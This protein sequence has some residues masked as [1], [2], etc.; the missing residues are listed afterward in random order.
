VF[1]GA[2]ARQDADKGDN[3]KRLLLTSMVALVS[4]ATEPM[5][6]SAA[7]AVPLERIFNPALTKQRPGTGSLIVKR[8]PG[9]KGSICAF[10]LHE[11]GKLF[12]EILP[13]EKVQIYLA[14]GD[15][16]IGLKT[17]M[18]CDNNIEASVTLTEGQ[19]RTYRAGMGGNNELLLHPTAF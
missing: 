10:R 16:I 17:D 5:P 13:G 4:C 9:F 1:K 2:T 3:M 7:V 11:G 15:H 19:T 8:D 14:P 6:T 18:M 12:A